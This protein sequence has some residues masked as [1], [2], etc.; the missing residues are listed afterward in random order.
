MKRKLDRLQRRGK[1]GREGKIAT[2]FVAEAM[3]A[4]SVY[5]GSNLAQ[6]SFDRKY[7]QMRR[8]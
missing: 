1:A 8:P 6:G 5:L 3:M 2:I 7:D 4:G